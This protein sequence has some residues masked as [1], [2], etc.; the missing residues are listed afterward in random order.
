M[1]TNAFTTR[2]DFLKGSAAATGALVIGFTLP[3]SSRFAQAAAAA[4]PGQAAGFAPNAYLRSAADGQVT[5]IC[6]LSEMGQGVHMGIASLVAEELDADWKSVKLEQAPVD[7]AYNNPLFGMQATGGSTAIRGHYE[8]SAPSFHFTTSA[9]R[10]FKAVQYP[11][12]ST[13]TPCGIRTTCF[14]PGMAFA[15]ASS[16]DTIVAPGT[17]A[18][19]MT[20]V[21]SPGTLT[22]MPNPA[23]P[24][25]L[26]GV[27]MRVRPLPRIRKSFGSLRLGCC[28]TG[29]FEAAATSSP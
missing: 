15:A 18:C 9:S 16:T 1:S 26:A 10:P 12:A 24:S 2:R 27:S 29:S 8:P 19:T 7:K 3:V 21:S 28:G 20:A 11:S 23:L 17:G 4:M 25:T 14:T 22:S 6:G 13:A 5:G